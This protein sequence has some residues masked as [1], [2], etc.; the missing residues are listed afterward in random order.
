MQ[1]TKLIP[2]IL[3]AV[4]ISFRATG[5]GAVD[6]HSHNVLPTFVEY[7]ESKGASLDETFPLPHWDVESHLTFMDSAGIETAM[8]SMPAPQPYFGN[9]EETKRIIRQY[10]EASAATWSKTCSSSTRPS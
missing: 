9:I 10:N 8:L 2:I 4:A 1:K 6:I 3:M 7:L 5:T